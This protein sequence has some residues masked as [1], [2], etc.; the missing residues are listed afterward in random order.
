MPDLSDRHIFIIPVQ[1]KFLLHAPLLK[2]SAL[3]NRSAAGAIR[4]ALASGAAAENAD[5][6]LQP[7]LDVLRQPPLPPPAPNG[8]EISPAFLGIVTT[9]ACNSACVYCDFGAPG[10]SGRAMDLQTAVAAVDWYARL[11]KQ[12]EKELLEI[13]FFGGEPMTAPAVVETVVHRA[14]LVAAR[15]RLT[16]Y[17]EISTNGLCGPALL[18]FLGDYVNRVV[19]SF[20]GRED[21]QNLHRPLRG[22]RGSYP[23]VFAAAQYLSDSPA[24]L[25]IRCCVSQINVDIMEDT[26]RWFCETFNPSLINFEIMQPVESAAAAGL[27][28]PDP[29]EFAANFIKA[30]RAAE[31]FGI[32]T[33]YAADLST[34][35]VYTSCPVGSDTVIVSPDGRISSCYLL[36]EKWQEVGLDLALGEMRGRRELAINPAAVQNIRAMVTNKPRCEK[37]FCRWNCAG[38]CHVGNT[39]P[40]CS[41]D[42]SDYCRQTRIISAC[43]LLDELNLP[44]MAD[45]LIDDREALPALACRES[46][47]L[48]EWE[49]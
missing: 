40:G 11:L 26:A 2:L 22:G 20:D 17:F 41:P 42:Y 8:A 38:G 31:S 35:P 32:K 28:P 34:E 25:V 4:A 46:D 7:L 14:R 3:V 37:C 48:M 10:A 9:R 12:Q 6:R 5:S 23:G 36:P 1:D 45:T 13:H 39:Y 43:S 29:Y 15:E 30:R 18:A 33:V 44:E 21:I 47:R 49:V 16:P 27:Y 24:Q 19:L